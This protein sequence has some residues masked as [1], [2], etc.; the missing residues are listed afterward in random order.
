VP[1][2]RAYCW[3]KANTGRELETDLEPFKGLLLGPVLHRRGHEHR[4]RGSC[5]PIRAGGGDRGRFLVIKAG[6]LWLMTR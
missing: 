5:W 3:P 6:V 2:W 1:S 4:L